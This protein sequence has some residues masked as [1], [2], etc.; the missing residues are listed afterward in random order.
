MNTR[1]LFVAMLA[2]LALGALAATPSNDAECE[3]CQWAVNELKTVVVQND[4]AAYILEAVANA[5][6]LLPTN[7]QSE[8]FCSV[9]FFASLF[10]F[11]E[12]VRGMQCSAVVKMY[13]YTMLE[14]L[15]NEIDPTQVCA[16]IGLCTSSSRMEVVR[17]AEP[18]IAVGGVLECKACDFVIGALENFISENSTEQVR[19]LVHFTL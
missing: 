9:V 7:L 5:C 15:D 2:V 4:T 8:V 12:W 6:Q 13:G 16:L 19:V 17:V 3:M 11:N 10:Q 18:E 14:Y 1:F